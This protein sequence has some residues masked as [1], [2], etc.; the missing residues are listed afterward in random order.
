MEQSVT[1]A[2]PAGKIAIMIVKLER[3]IERTRKQAYEKD[4]PVFHQKVK[5]LRAKRNYWAQI[6]SATEEYKQMPLVWWT[7]FLLALGIAQE[8]PE[9]EISRRVRHNKRQSVHKHGR[10]GRRK[11][12]ALFIEEWA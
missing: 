7:C 4:D 9:D 5:A 1:N 2:P 10:R 12:D 3:A 6:L 11:V 8:L